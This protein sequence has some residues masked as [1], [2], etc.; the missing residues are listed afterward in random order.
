[1]LLLNG[2]HTLWPGEILNQEQSHFVVMEI[3]TAVLCRAQVV[4]QKITLTAGNAR[5]LIS[6]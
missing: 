4:A 5:A 2:V 3:V 1:L 6:V